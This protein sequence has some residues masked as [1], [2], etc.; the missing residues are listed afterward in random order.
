[1]LALAVQSGR[2]LVLAVLIFLVFRLDFLESAA[3]L[4]ASFAGYL[5]WLAGHVFTLHRNSL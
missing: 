5:L 4:S 1:M 2:G 3:F